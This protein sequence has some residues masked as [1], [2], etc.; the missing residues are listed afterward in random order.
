MKS[1][2]LSKPHMITVVG[3]PGSG[4]TFFAEK[5]ADTFHA[6]Y[7][8]YEKIMKFTNDDSK[9]ADAVFAYQLDEL[10]KTKQSVIVEGCTETRNQRAD[11]AQKAR[12]SEY[13]ILLVWVQTDP[14]TAK[15]RAVKEKKGHSKTTL[16]S[17]DYDR[18]A[19]RFNAP[20]AIEKPIVISGKHTYASQ[21]KVVLKKLSTPRAEISTHTT[22]PVRT[23]QPTRRNI[24]I[25]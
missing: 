11:L 18:Q 13:E 10:L 8:S 12:A 4:K 9:A 19:K 22:A 3:L 25:R 14:T 1:L 23:D 2:S 17:E 15:T 5:F 21:A 20:T 7:V 16:S 24:T 6:P